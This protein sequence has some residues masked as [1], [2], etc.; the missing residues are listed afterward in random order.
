LKPR[1]ADLTNRNLWS[2][3]EEDKPMD[4]LIWKEEDHKKVFTSPVLSIRESS[5]RSPEG[6]LKV[7]TV[8]DAPDWAIVVPV[9]KTPRGKEFVMVRQWRHGSRELSLE[10]PGGVFEEGEAGIEA[11]ARELREET[12]YTAGKIRKI[13]ELSPNPAIM[14]NRVHFF[15]AEDLSHRGDQDLDDDEYVDVEIIPME[16]AFHG[17]GHPPYIHALM[18]SAFVLYLQATGG[19]VPGG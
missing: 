6:A 15:L 7:F 14:A 13:G 17:M 2:I 4:H 1:E 3:F 18:A 11:A 10:F 9:V 12:G 5:S 8:I 16:T 19:R